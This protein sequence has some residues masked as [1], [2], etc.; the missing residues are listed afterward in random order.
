M[1]PPASDDEEMTEEEMGDDAKEA[2][3]TNAAEAGE[4]QVRRKITRGQKMNFI[5]KERSKKE[6]RTSKWR[7]VPETGIRLS[8]TLTAVLCSGS[9]G[10]WASSARWYE[11]EWKRAPSVSMRQSVRAN[12]IDVCATNIFDCALQTRCSYGYPSAPTSDLP[13]FTISQKNIGGKV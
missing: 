5:E 10:H 3:A 2:A 13:P 8:S 7:I 9:A 6:G 12:N 1:P 11:P 4:V